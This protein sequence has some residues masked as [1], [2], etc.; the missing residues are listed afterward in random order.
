MILLLMVYVVLVLVSPISPSK[1]QFV[2]TENICGLIRFSMS[3]QHPP[4]VNLLV[5]IIQ[6]D[7]LMVLNLVF[8]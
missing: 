2:D 6:L 4:W 7:I 5:G 1:K 8:L 3:A